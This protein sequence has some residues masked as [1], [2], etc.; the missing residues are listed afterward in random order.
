MLSS[1][2]LAAV[3]SEELTSNAPKNWTLQVMAEEK[4]LTGGNRFIEGVPEPQCD[5]KASKLTGSVFESHCDHLKVCKL[6]GG[7]F[8]QQYDLLNKLEGNDLFSLLI[9]QRLDVL[10]VGEGDFTFTLAFAVLRNRSKCG[11]E[12]LEPAAA[13]K[14]SKSGKALSEKPAKSRKATPCLEPWKGIT[15]TRYEPTHGL[16][17]DKPVLYFEEV[18]L[19]CIA[20]AAAYSCSQLEKISTDRF[21]GSLIPAAEHQKFL[22]CLQNLDCI[23]QFP[24]PPGG[25][26]RY[27]IDARDIPSDLIPE[28]GVVW[29]QCPWVPSD[30]KEQGKTSELITAFLQGLVSKTQYV[31]VGVTSKSKYLEMYNI[32]AIKEKTKK[33]YQYIGHDSEL[34]KMVLSFGYHHVSV[35]SDYKDIHSMLLDHHVTWFS[36]EF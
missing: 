17:R 16:K 10:F 28:D 35:I 9:E 2:L 12:K 7:V 1:R 32:E 24:P 11:K 30:T 34:V 31:C 19:K 25:S 29:F 18:Q 8:E 23:K 15:S 3:P 4:K 27:G 20:S 21:E 6:R 22:N 14:S 33:E 26:W 36:K 5:L 13:L